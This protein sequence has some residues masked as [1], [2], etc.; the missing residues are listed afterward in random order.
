MWSRW[1]NP[2][3]IEH[4][5]ETWDCQQALP[6]IDGVSNID[7]VLP[8]SGLIDHHA[9]PATGGVETPTKCVRFIIFAAGEGRLQLG[10]HGNLNGF[11]PGRYVVSVSSLVI[12]GILGTAILRSVVANGG[13]HREEDASTKQGA[14][15]HLSVPMVV[16]PDDHTAKVELVYDGSFGFNGYFDTLRIRKLSPVIRV[17]A[18]SHNLVG[19][20]FRATRS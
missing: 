1:N 13:V 3:V 14:W 2:E 16:A 4:F 8:A 6:S 17:R 9:P 5:I 7:W 12:Y 11:T 19:H 20:A 15:Q 18:L 10:W